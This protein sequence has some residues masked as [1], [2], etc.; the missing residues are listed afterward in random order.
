MAVSRRHLLQ[1]TTAAQAQAQA[2]HTAGPLCAQAT[3]ASPAC[4][5]LA[6]A[7]HWS[8]YPVVGPLL[9]VLWAL[10]PVAAWWSSRVDAGDEDP[11]QPR[12]R[13][14]LEKLAHDTWRFFE[15]VVGPEDNHLPP[16]NLQLEPQPTIAHRTSPT[17][18][19]MYLLATCCAREFRWID[20]GACSRAWPPR[21]T[22][23][24]ACR[25]TTATCSTGTTR[26]R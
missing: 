22:P 16:D 7:A 4:L 3:R 10:A 5:A 26:K 25:S 18:I 20:T 24:T 21:S 6:V 23:W 2:S 9:F 13:S 19:G 8:A 17:N 1:W 12:P 11:L 14:Y 15:H